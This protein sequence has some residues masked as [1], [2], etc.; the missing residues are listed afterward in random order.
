[1]RQ[2]KKASILLLMCLLSVGSLMATDVFIGVYGG[3]FIPKD[4]RFKEIYSNG[5]QIGSEMNWSLE[6]MV[7][8]QLGFYYQTADG[9]LSVSKE[10]TKIRIVP[11][12]LSLRMQKPIK[13]IVP[14]IG[15]GFGFYYFRETNVIG[16]VSDSKFGF[17]GETGLIV[18]VSKRI[19]FD[20]R[21]RYDSCKVKP[22]DI[23]ANIGGSHFIA[24]LLYRF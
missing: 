14:Y 17:F 20:F 9:E 23:A 19:G 8:L 2:M 15:G 24:G 11:I 18:W 13:M 6:E 12:T 22:T 21:Y 1:M 10:D 5:T 16:T 3:Y 4:E 7:S